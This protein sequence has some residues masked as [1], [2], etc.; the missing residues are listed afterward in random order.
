MEPQAKKSRKKAPRLQKNK[1][2]KKQKNKQKKKQA[3]LGM[4]RVLSDDANEQ[5]QGETKVRAVSLQPTYHGDNRDIDSPM[6]ECLSL[7][8]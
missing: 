2:T 8:P 7:I 3:R 5:A 4:A 1:K 6:C